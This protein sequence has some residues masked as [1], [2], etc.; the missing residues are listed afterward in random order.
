MLLLLV[1]RASAR[2]SSAHLEP[3]GKPV[4]H[5]E[6]VSLTE[7][8]R[9][10]SHPFPNEAAGI[11]EMF[12]RDGVVSSATCMF[13][14]R[15]QVST[16][17]SLLLCSRRGC[18]S[19]LDRGDKL[20]ACRWELAWQSQPPVVLTLCLSDLLAWEVCLSLFVGNGF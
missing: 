13:R 2:H 17:F 16:S 12:L 6:A 18:V 20:S 9:K 8:F 14:I 19:H 7:L 1:S 15:K 10:D 5:R 11:I 3:D 4:E